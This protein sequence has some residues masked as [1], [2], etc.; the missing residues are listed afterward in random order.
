MTVFSGVLVY[1]VIWWLVLFTVLPWGIR[2]SEQPEPGHAVEAPANPR[3]FLRF[4]I[5]T[6]IA[7]VLFGIAWWLIDSDL[8]SFRAP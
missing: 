8:V 2:R 4:A 6:V 7:T 3:I 1:A 5:T